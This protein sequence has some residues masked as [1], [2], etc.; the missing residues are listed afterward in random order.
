M[1]LKPHSASQQQVLP[2][3]PAAAAGQGH[4]TAQRGCSGDVAVSAAASCGPRAGCVSAACDPPI[5]QDTSNR[6]RT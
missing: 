6:P 1:Q 5:Q 3:L 4:G 2:V